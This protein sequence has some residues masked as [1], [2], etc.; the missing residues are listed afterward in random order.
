MRTV[1]ARGSVDDFTREQRC[2]RA[3]YRPD[4]FAE[5]DEKNAGKL[6][7]GDLKNPVERFSLGSLVTLFSDIGR[8]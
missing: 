8:S 4:S 5:N 6:G 1:S 2:Y 7:T 3:E